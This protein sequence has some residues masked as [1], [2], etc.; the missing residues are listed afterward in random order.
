M[1]EGDQGVHLWLGVDASGLAELVPL[2]RSVESW[3]RSQGVRLLGV[4]CNGR[5]WPDSSHSSIQSQEEP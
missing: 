4:T 3:L 5:R 2:M 1:W